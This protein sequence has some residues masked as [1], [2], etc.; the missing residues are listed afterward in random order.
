MKRRQGKNLW[1]ASVNYAYGQI[2]WKETVFLMVFLMRISCEGLRL[3]HSHHPYKGMR[4]EKVEQDRPVS[5]K[6]ERGHI[7]KMKQEAL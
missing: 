3:S 1:Q 7:S 2:Y 5:R 6:M 4:R